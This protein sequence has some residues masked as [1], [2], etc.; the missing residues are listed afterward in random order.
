MENTVS[1]V[2][3][4]VA[5]V[6]FLFFLYRRD[7]DAAKLD[8]KGT[9]FMTVIPTVIHLLICVLI[10]WNKYV[11][12]F[13]SEAYSLAQLLSPDAHDITEQPVWSVA[14]ASLLVT[15]IPAIGVWLGCLSAQKNRRREVAALR[16]E[17]ERH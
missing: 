12:I 15:P 9:V 8:S 10:C 17:G 7:D 1:L 2:I 4:L 6:L 5:S 13:L 3:V 14:V 11:Y 16:K